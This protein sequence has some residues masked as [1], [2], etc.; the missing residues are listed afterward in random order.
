MSGVGQDGE[1]LFARLKHSLQALALPAEV[2]LS[3]LPDF[4]CTADELALDFDHWSTCVLSNPEYQ[5][6]DWQR[7]LLLRLNHTLEQMSGEGNQSLWTEQAL[8]NRPEWQRVR[9]QAEAALATFQWGVERLPSYKHE[10]IQ[11]TKI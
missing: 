9:E 2:Q 6:T 5:M 3:L 11:G 7:T 8:R 10:Y 4:V 1:S